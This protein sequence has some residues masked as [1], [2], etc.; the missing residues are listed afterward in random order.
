MFFHSQ[1]IYYVS[2]KKSILNQSKFTLHMLYYL[3]YNHKPV[4]LEIHLTMYYFSKKGIA[5]SYKEIA[6]VKETEVK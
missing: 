4:N 1:H 3:F 6:P 5:K 2:V